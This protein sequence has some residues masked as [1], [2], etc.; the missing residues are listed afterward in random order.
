MRSISILTI[1]GL[2]L[3]FLLGSF[4]TIQAQCKSK[5]VLEAD[6]DY[7]L[8]ESSTFDPCDS[9]LRWDFYFDRNSEQTSAGD[10]VLVFEIHG[11]SD[12]HEEYQADEYEEGSY[13]YYEVKHIGTSS[14]E[15]MVISATQMQYIHFEDIEGV[16][17]FY[18]S[19]PE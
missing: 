13:H 10:K 6:D 8:N 5:E 18:A 14:E 9:W 2:I 17:A 19:N 11:Q 12:V 16:A 1:F 15:R 7:H 4:D 3:L